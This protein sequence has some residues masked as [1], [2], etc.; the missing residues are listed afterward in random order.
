[1]KSTVCRTLLVAALGFML[2]AFSG[3][4][5]GGDVH[6]KAF[7]ATGNSCDECIRAVQNDRNYCNRLI[8]IC[9]VDWF[10]DP[11]EAS[12][13]ALCECATGCAPSSTISKPSPSTQKVKATDD[14]L[15]CDPPPKEIFLC[16]RNGG[17]FNY[18]TCQC[19]FN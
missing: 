5:N 8:D 6:A 2:I 10:V 14:G 7:A 9:G 13:A 17:T 19:E 3:F 12:P 15:P 1:M 16:Q 11:C 18:A 4:R